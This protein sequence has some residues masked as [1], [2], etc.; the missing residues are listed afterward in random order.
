M[1]VEAS[2]Q[3]GEGSTTD[4]IERFRATIDRRPVDRPC[5]WLG[6]PTEEAWPGLLQYFGC[7][8]RNALIE[9]L[10]D[11][12]APVELPY[13]SPT[14]NAIY[15]AFDFA[16]DPDRD[17]AHRTL[18]TRGFFAGKR[19][20]AAV[21]DF[22]WPDPALHIAPDECR[23]AVAA[24]PP[25]RVVLGVLWSAHFQDACAAFGMEDSLVAMYEA[26]ELYRAIIDRI[27]EFYLKANRIFYEAAGDALH[28]VLI[29]NDFG[30]QTG[31]M[32][33]PEL[34]REF[35]L[36]GTRAL[37]G[38]SKAYGLRVIH[39]SCGAI[40]PIIGDLIEAGA[41]VIH[42]IQALAAGMQPEALKAAYGDRVAFCGGVDSQYLLVRGAP[43]DVR[44]RVRELRQVFPT[45]LIISP[46]H[47]AILPDI[48]P[49]NVAAF[50]EAAR[51]LDE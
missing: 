11:D 16:N 32:L 4:H 25:G 46:G 41:D 40:A 29:G 18:T 3:T 2:A 22:D 21:D 43:D 8:S 50:M 24:A 14:S 6:L 49:E 38:Q 10:D 20:P 33:S 35:V 13:H 26:P 39:H 27:T 23:R 47:E 19:D 7:D 51:E 1:Q 42:P 48:P 31:L 15:A 36:P 34:I 45:G 17:P 28:A 37:I 12:I 9:H 30:S 5:T 44:A